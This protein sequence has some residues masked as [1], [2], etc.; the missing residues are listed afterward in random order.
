MLWTRVIFAGASAPAKL[1][2]W[3]PADGLCRSAVGHL[4]LVVVHRLAAAL[5]STDW[6]KPVSCSLVDVGSN[7][8]LVVAVGPVEREERRRRSG[9][10]SAGRRHLPRSRRPL[11][12]CPLGRSTVISPAQVPHTPYGRPEAAHERATRQSDRYL[13]V[14]GLGEAELVPRLDVAG[15]EVEVV[16]DDAIDCNLQCSL[17]SCDCLGIV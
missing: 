1:L 8:A 3:S 9:G 4:V 12:P 5:E 10:R 13:E 14:R 15:P 6:S 16:I 2:S 11:S 17:A 7:V